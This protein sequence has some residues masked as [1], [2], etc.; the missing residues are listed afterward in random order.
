MMKSCQ[1]H[2]GCFN[3]D[4]VLRKIT[5]S[6]CQY[7]IKNINPKMSLCLFVYYYYYKYVEHTEADL[8]KT[9]SLESGSRLD[10]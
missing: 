4:H 8:C 5:L 6:F 9:W 3:S 10:D 2:C 7:L 1:G